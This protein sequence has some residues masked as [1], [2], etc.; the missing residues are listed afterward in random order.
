MT[1]QGLFEY[2]RYDMELPVTRRM[3]KYAVMRWEVV[4]TRLGNGNYFSKRDGL[5]SIRSRKAMTRRYFTIKE[6]AEDL[7]VRRDEEHVDRRRGAARR[8]RL[9]QNGFGRAVAHHVHGHLDAGQRAEAGTGQPSKRRQSLRCVQG[10]PPLLSRPVGRQLWT[11]T[12]RPDEGSDL[13]RTA[14]PIAR[15]ASAPVDLT[16]LARFHAHQYVGYRTCVISAPP[17]CESELAVA[18]T[19]RANWH[20]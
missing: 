10:P 16:S 15:A 8:R 5:E 7:G 4:P 9:V 13:F 11:R 3:I 20:A 14:E 1:E 19:S 12:D 2:L 17:V 6:A 18:T